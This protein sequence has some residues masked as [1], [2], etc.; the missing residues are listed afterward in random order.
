MESFRSSVFKFLCRNSSQEDP[1]FCSRAPTEVALTNKW[2][3][4]SWCFLPYKAL[5][6]VCRAMS[7][8][9]ESESWEHPWEC[10]QTQPQC[11]FSVNLIKIIFIF[12][13]AILSLGIITSS[14]NHR[15]TLCQAA[16]ALQAQQNSGV[17]ELLIIPGGTDHSLSW[18][19]NSH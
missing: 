9:W 4:F 12:L 7:W 3:N 10:F 18:H 1:R 5:A 17:P 15:S 8:G 11:T 13:P 6:A 19:Q 16:P 2:V 14:A